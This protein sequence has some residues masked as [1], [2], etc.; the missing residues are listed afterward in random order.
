MNQ[1]I[2][3]TVLT[4]I[5]GTILFALSEFIRGLFIEP[6]LRI[7]A[8]TG[9]I[10][11]KIIYYSADLTS[12]GKITIGREKEIREMLRALSTGLRAK[13]QTL[14]LYEYWAFIRLVPS[15]KDIDLCARG[16]M[17]LSNNFSWE[18]DRCPPGHYVADYQESNALIIQIQNAL[19]L[20]NK[21]IPETDV[22]KA[23]KK[24]K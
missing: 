3:T 4:L 18:L 21:I 11:D 19:R 5:G 12:G 16:L 6:I 7:R 10:V 15:N 23:K 24:T 14:P 9:D 13:E 20:K 1:A 2:L 17:G 8:L 22:K